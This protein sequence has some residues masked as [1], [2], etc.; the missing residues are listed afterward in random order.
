MHLPNYERE[1]IGCSCSLP[2]TSFSLLA[3]HLVVTS[4]SCFSIPLQGKGSKWRWGT[5]CPAN[6]VRDV[7]TD[8]AATSIAINWSISQLNRT[9]L[10]VEVELNFD[11]SLIFSLLFTLTTLSFFFFFYPRH[12][13]KEAIAFFLFFFSRSILTLEHYLWTHTH[14]PTQTKGGGGDLN[15]TN[16][17]RRSSFLSLSLISSLG[18]LSP[19]HTNT[20]R[21]ADKVRFSF[22]YRFN[23]S[24]Y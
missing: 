8:A 9:E 1:R 2:A 3:C 12:A 16:L 11:L 5:R 6:C 17:E 10:E 7:L 23:F 22:S 24:I 21:Q 19:L 18:H 20:D 14:A 4:S 15:W 13:L